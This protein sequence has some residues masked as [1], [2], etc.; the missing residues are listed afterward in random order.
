MI[1]GII[2]DIHS[3]I[4]AL[5]S[6]MDDAK[7][8]GAEGFICLGDIVGYGANPHE[9][10]AKVRSSSQFVVAGNHD[11]AVCQKTDITYFN[12]F[13]RRAV[14]WTLQELDEGEKQYLSGLPLVYHGPNFS[15]AH[16]SLNHPEDWEYILTE[17][18]ADRSF[19]LLEKKVL[20]VGH[21]H[22]PGVFTYQEERI[23]YDE[24]SEMSLGNSSRYIVNVGSVGQP[25]DMDPRACY[26]LFDEA[27]GHVS[28]HRVAYNFR[29]TQQKILDAKLPDIL[30]R[31]LELGR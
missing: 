2:S 10:I 6:V 29:E 7:D 8:R 22:L 23:R 9:C 12:S 20:F 27:L 5:N 16:G 21:S 25:R 26:C 14:E 19:A 11:Y 3:N 31:R 28:I 24:A 15:L 30:A 1:Y 17:D 13:A 4:E 18:D